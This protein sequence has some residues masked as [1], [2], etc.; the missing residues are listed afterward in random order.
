MTEAMTI[1]RS[2]AE[3]AIA[4]L[5]IGGL[6]IAGLAIAG[7]AIAGLANVGF[8]CVH[9]GDFYDLDSGDL[10]LWVGDGL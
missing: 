5:A 4:G 8:F 3:L 1:S 9:C 6:A 7:L 2:D 10:I